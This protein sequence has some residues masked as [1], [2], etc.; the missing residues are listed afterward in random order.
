MCL[1]GKKLQFF[2]FC[3]SG[4][5]RSFFLALDETAGS[6]VGL[7]PVRGCRRT[8]FW[9]SNA[10]DTLDFCEIGIKVSTNRDLYVL[11]TLFRT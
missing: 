8:C 9:S 3:I 7:N 6:S 2:N 5:F 11:S 10:S 1:Q 4:Y